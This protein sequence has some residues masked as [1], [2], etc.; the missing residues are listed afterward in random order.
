MPYTSQK[1]AS[2]S[3]VL[4]LAIRE[5]VFVLG[6]ALLGGAVLLPFTAYWYT[7][8]IPGAVLSAYALARMEAVG[9]TGPLTA[10]EMRQYSAGGR[11]RVPL[12]RTFV[13]I[14]LTALTAPPLAV[15]YLPMAFK[16]RPLPELA[17]RTRLTSLDRRLDPRPRMEIEASVKNA[18]QRFRLLT[19]A[20]LVA[21]AAM[22]V[23]NARAPEVIM[24][25]GGGNGDELPEHERELLIQYLELTNLHPQELEYHVRLASLYYRNGME[26]DLA[27]ELEI[28]AAIDPEHAIL[29][30]ADTTGFHF[31]MITPEEPD[32]L[33]PDLTVPELTSVAPAEQDSVPADTMVTDSIDIPQDTVNVTLEGSPSP[34]DTSAADESPLEETPPET[35]ETVS[36]QLE[37]EIEN[38]TVEQEETAVEPDTL[39][40]S[41]G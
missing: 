40:P 14:L 1:P 9:R 38:E 27:E 4:A 31:G 3:K 18:R 21:S 35:L 7:G 16:A 20:P 10:L 34:P 32:T 2:A 12:W 13:R 5:T 26:R 11:R 24:V 22:F 6:W 29:I 30:L 28:I 23:L 41:E 19:A 33:S 39:L 25:Q 17:S 36:D 8:I 37:I 15:G